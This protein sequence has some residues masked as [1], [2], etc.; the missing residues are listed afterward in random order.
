M[1]ADEYG[2]FAN[3]V[4]IACA[5]VATFS[6]LLL[7]MIG[8]LKRWTWL[9]GGSPSFLVTAGARMLAVALM[10]ATYVTISSTNYLWFGGAAVICG[11]IGFVCVVKFDGMRQQYVLSIPLVAADGGPLRDRRGR[12][13]RASI[14]IGSEDQMRAEAASAFREAREKRGVSLPKFISGYGSPVNDPESIWEHSLLAQIANRLTTVLMCVVLLAVITLFLAAFTIEAA[15]R[16]GRT[17]TQNSPRDSQTH[18]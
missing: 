17:S 11:L 6:I 16:D 14:V 13:Q 10:A 12:D 3:I 5:L 7:K 18:P 8:G 1:N 9:A 2:P 15:G 4:A